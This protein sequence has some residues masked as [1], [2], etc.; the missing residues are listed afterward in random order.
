MLHLWS[1]ATWNFEITHDAGHPEWIDTPIT[2]WNIKNLRASE[3]N[4]FDGEKWTIRLP[5][6]L[7]LL[8]AWYMDEVCE[9]LYLTCIDPRGITL[10]KLLDE[11]EVQEDIPKIHLAGIPLSHWCGSVYVSGVS[12]IVV[13]Y[14]HEPMS[15][16]SGDRK[17]DQIGPNEGRQSALSLQVLSKAVYAGTQTAGLSGSDAGTSHPFVCRWHEFAAYCTSVAGE[18]PNSCQLGQC[19]CGQFA[20]C[21]ALAGTQRHH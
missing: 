7:N 2:N 4:T 6:S 11:I 8:T 12:D 19:L 18:S 1:L 15:L 9:H 20:R 16:L 5:Q 21:P 14:G 13:K 17:S 3:G 10:L